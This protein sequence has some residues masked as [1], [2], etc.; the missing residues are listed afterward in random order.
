MKFKPLYLAIAI[1]IC[2]LLH[3][4]LDA[5][6]GNPNTGQV[7]QYILNGLKAYKQHG[8]EAAVKIWLKDSPYE[9]GTQMASQIAFFKNIEMLY[10]RYLSYD[11]ISVI[12]TDTS[13]R[14]Y[15]RMNY[16]RTAGYILFT[17]IRKNGKWVLGH[18]DLD[19]IQKYASR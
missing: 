1:L 16:E 19:R 18:I 5:I 15:V 2:I 10:G 6:P 14:V 4:R 3:T 11:I 13:N 17:S 8:Y 9:A 7:P 12:E